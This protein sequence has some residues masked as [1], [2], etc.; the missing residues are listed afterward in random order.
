M[1]IMIN[2]FANDRWL[3]NGVELLF[4]SKWKSSK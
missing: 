2:K 1:N 3:K 4:E